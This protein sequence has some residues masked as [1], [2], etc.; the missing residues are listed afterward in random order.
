[1]RR[2]SLPLSAIVHG[3]SD[4]SSDGDADDELDGGAT[5]FDWD[6]ADDSVG[7][8]VPIKG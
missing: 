2:R 5:I 3:S 4:G 7:L 8:S 6:G 1:M